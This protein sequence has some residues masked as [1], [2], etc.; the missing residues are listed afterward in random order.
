MGFGGFGDGES[1]AEAAIEALGEVAGEF[2]VL[3]LVFA[4]GDEGGVVEENVGRHEDG[5]VEDA[6]VG[7]VL[8]FGLFFE[9]GHARHFS[10]GGKAV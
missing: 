7:A 5:V 10:H 8:A 1:V 6:N 2:E 4:D 9:L 3:E